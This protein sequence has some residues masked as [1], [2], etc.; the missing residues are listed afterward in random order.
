VAARRSRLHDAALR[1]WRAA[2]AAG[3]PA[4]LLR[5]A[6]RVDGATPSPPGRGLAPLG[7]GL[8]PL[9]VAVAGLVASPAASHAQTARLSLEQVFNRPATSLA[10]P[11]GAVD[12]GC[13]SAPAFG[14]TCSAHPA[15]TFATWYGAIQLRARLTGAA[16]GATLRLVAA[17]SPGGTMPS[18]RLIDGPTGGPPTTPFPIAPESPLTLAG[19]IPQGNTLITRSI[20]VRIFVTDPAGAWSSSIVYSLIVE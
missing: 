3:H 11:F 1:V 12:A 10:V 2:L 5:R 19:A 9:A 15:G 8:A 7:R 4:P 17:R 13:T 18:D 20:G 14:V 6:F 16:G